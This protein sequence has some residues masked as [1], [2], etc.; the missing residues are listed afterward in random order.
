MNTQLENINT[1]SDEKGNLIGLVRRDPV[2]KKHLV[3]FVK[4]ASSEDI[5]NKF[6]GT[7]PMIVKSVD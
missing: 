1:I 2:S 7:K 6:F 5:I 3:Y 4:E